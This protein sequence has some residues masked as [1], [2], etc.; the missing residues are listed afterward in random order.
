MLFP[1][2]ENPIKYI[3]YKK[4]LAIKIYI[5]EEKMEKR[6]LLFST[7]SFAITVTFFMF[8]SQKVFCAPPEN[9][10]IWR[11]QFK[12]RTANVKDA[13]TDDDIKV[14]LNNKHTN[15]IDYA[16]DDFERND[17]FTYDLVL[18]NVKFLSNI[19][20]IKITK[21]G[22]DAWCL[23]SFEL[24]VNGKTIYFQD[25]GSSGRWIGD[26]H[27]SVY[28]VDYATLRNN[29][30]W[31]N[32]T[33]PSIPMLITRAEIESRI[34]AI[35]GNYIHGT[36]LY[37]GHLHGRGVEAWKKNGKT[38]HFDLDLALEVKYWFD[39]EVDIDFDLNI[40]CTNG[41]IVLGTS[42]FDADVDWDWFTDIVTLSI[43]NLVSDKMAKKLTSSLQTFSYT[44]NT[45]LP[46]C[47]N[48]TVKDNGDIQFSF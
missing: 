36:R 27:P 8:I 12:L 39:P 38:L 23:R 20:Q 9:L 3:I 4:P 16:R 6:K 22:S 46:I 42:N 18:D 24:L 11:V 47:P 32:Y 5:L 1:S 7:I 15:W 26:G 13:G 21:T 43:V 25:F 48:I 10:P 30:Y 40:S 31:K 44:N 41:K 35:I 34:E 33:L 29:N 37:W 28:T 14:E 2:L 17:T 19:T 45:G